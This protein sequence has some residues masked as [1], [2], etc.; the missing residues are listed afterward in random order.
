MLTWQNQGHSD[1]LTLFGI[2]PRLFNRTLCG[3]WRQTLH[4]ER[5]AMIVGGPPDSEAMVPPVM[6]NQ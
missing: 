2:L 6:K 5:T 1:S 3:C 4:E